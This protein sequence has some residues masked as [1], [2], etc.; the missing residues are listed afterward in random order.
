MLDG[1]DK[2]LE[3][4]GHRF[5][6]YADDGNIYVRSVRAGERVMGSVSRFLDKKLKLKVNQE[7]SA[8]ARPGERK[9][10][11]FSFTSGK[12]PK[13]RIAPR[14]WNASSCGSGN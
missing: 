12:E 10:L 2:E 13:R 4:R 9:F 8:A 11:G 5:G 3:R 7:K 14:P 6:R 1:L